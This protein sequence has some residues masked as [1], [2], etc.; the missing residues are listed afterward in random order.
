MVILVQN[1]LPP[2]QLNILQLRLPNRHQTQSE[3]SNDQ[4]ISK[5]QQMALVNN[6]F[7]IQIRRF[8]PAIAF[9]FESHPN[10]N[11]YLMFHFSLK[12]CKRYFFFVRQN[13]CA[14]WQLYGTLGVGTEHF[15]RVCTNWV[16][17]P[18]LEIN[19]IFLMRLGFLGA[20]LRLKWVHELWNEIGLALGMFFIFEYLNLYYFIKFIPVMD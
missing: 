16:A 6:L 2:F 3:N 8:Y 12:E 14:L 13:P 1:M 17:T 5:T 15:V 4:T 10:S 19:E 9:T 20:F 11:G 18:G 7:P